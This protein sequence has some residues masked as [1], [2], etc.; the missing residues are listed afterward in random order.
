MTREERG[1]GYARMSFKFLS[2]T[3]TLYKINP[4]SPP[5]VNVCQS[6][7]ASEMGRS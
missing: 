7:P 3:Y 2:S 4:W 5:T 1:K 6:G